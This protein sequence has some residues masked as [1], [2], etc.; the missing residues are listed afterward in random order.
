MTLKPPLPDCAAVCRC[1]ATRPGSYVTDK[2]SRGWVRQ[3]SHGGRPL[4]GTL[5]TSTGVREF[6]VSKRQ[7]SN[8]N[9]ECDIRYNPDDDKVH[10]QTRAN[11]FTWM[12]SRGWLVGLEAAANPV[13]A[14][15]DSCCLRSPKPLRLESRSPS[16]PRRKPLCIAS[17]MC[18][19]ASCGPLG[20]GVVGVLTSYVSHFD[21]P[22]LRARQASFRRG[23]L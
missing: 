17:E 23:Y 5:F 3:Q 16:S 2:K 7:C 15:R 20:A 8:R 14:H 4:V 11:A 13:L 22:W 1:P 9:C 21:G 19:S 12:V 18:C 6:T 10:M